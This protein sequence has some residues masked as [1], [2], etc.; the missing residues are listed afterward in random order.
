MF[1]YGHSGELRSLPTSIPNM[2]N[3]IDVQGHQ[4]MFRNT[5]V[6]GPDKVNEVSFSIS[7]LESGNV[8]ARA[9]AENVVAALNIPGV[10]RDFPLYWGVPNISI[11]GLTGPGEASDTPFIN[12]DTI[13]QLNDNFSWTKGK[14]SLKMGGEV[15]RIRYNQLGG[16]VPRGRFTFNGQF[17]NNP[18]VST[19]STAA[20][21]MADFLLGI[22]SASEGQVGAPIAN[23]RSEERRVGKECRL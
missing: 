2:A 1:R 5:R 17:T 6:I 11:S 21:A 9:G 15:W 7:R 20:N 13:I 16:V 10:S 18:I 19:S 22:M 23:Y 4:G 14:H 3:N 12:W 8:A